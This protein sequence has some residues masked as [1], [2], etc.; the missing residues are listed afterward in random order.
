MLKLRFCECYT[1]LRRADKITCAVSYVI[2]TYRGVNMILLDYFHRFRVLQSGPRC[3]AL[4]KPVRS[5]RL[6]EFTSILRFSH[7]KCCWLEFKHIRVTTQ[8]S[9]LKLSRSGEQDC[10]D[11][12]MTCKYATHLILGVENCEDEAPFRLLT[13]VFEQ[14]IVYSPQQ[15][16][17]ELQIFRSYRFLCQ[18][19][20]QFS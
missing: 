2:A 5:N 15:K 19:S 11:P 7:S 1:T 17:K 20:L 13:I 9:A 12:P 8:G 14:N 6:S 18:G 4:Y 16:A 3:R 10:V